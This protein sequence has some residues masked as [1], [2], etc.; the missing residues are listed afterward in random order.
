MNLGSVA[1]ADA[2]W[3]GMNLGSV[4]GADA[5]WNGNRA[6]IGFA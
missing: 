2:Y 3:N 4:A 6:T 5:Y 1:G